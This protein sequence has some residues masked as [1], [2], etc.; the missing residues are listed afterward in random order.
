[1]LMGYE[2]LNL[3]FD[4][5]ANEYLQLEGLKL[6]TS[7]DWAVWLPDYLD[8]FEPDPLR[9]VLISNMPE[10][11]DSDFSWREYVRSNND[12]L[13]ATYG[14]LVHRVLTMSYRNFDGKVPVPVTVDDISNNLLLEAANRFSEVTTCIEACKFRAALNSTMSLARAANQY[15]DLKEPWRTVKNNRDD[16]ATTLWTSLTV[17]NCLKIA[18]YPFLP[19]SSEKLHRMMGFSD[20]IRDQG[21]EWSPDALCRG[22]ILSNPEPLFTK[23]DESIIERETKRIGR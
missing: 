2:G 13:V 14:N 6:S 22:Q 18:L 7:R 19:F 8:S 12:E 17:I 10:T 16:A 15:L 4:V 20:S 3:P 9:Y 5:P 23:L 21:W 11:S 1:M